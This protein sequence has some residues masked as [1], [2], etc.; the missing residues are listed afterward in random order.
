VNRRPRTLEAIFYHFAEGNANYD[1]I[2]IIIMTTIDV[3][4]VIMWGGGDGCR[5]FSHALQ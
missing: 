2:I 4:V 1:I 3:V 5:K